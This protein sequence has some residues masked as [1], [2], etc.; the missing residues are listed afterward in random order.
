MRFD[1]GTVCETVQT[2]HP[3][4]ANEV[5]E[6]DD[7]NNVGHY[8]VIKMPEFYD[9]TSDYLLWMAETNKVTNH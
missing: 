5:M 7:F 6:A 3:S 4:Q 9:V 8:T 1:T 2:I